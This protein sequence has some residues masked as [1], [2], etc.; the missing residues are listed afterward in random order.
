M[1]AGDTPHEFGAA[2]AGWME[3]LADDGSG[4]RS[5]QRPRRAG[6]GR[7]AAAV[8]AGAEELAWLTALYARA[9]YSPRAPDTAEQARAVQVW[10]RLRWRLLLAQLWQ[11]WLPGRE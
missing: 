8:A 2:L 7:V 4:G 11:R 9:N 5:L 3:G 6:Q 10:G 1:Q